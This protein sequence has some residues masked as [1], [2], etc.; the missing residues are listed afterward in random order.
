M[1]KNIKGFTLIELIVVIAIIG[2]LAAILVPSMMGFILN[3][4]VTK[5]DSNAKMIYTG[6]QAGI[7]ELSNQKIDPVANAIYLKEASGNDAV[8]TGNSNVEVNLYLGDNFKGYYGFKI[9]SSG[10]GVEFAIWSDI[11]LTEADVVQMS[12]EDVETSMQSAKPIGCYPLD[13]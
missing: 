5:H 9:D 12:K 7:V 10:S 1:K 13:V 2:V 6:A 8:S 3:A 4:K 11:P